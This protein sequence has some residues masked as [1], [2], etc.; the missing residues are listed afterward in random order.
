MSETVVV[1]ARG[2]ACPM[3]VIKAK[4]ALE[5]ARPGDRI[6][7]M[8]DGE[9]ARDNVSRMAKTAGCA[10]EVRPEAMGFRLRIT[11]GAPLAAGTA[12]AASCPGETP[13]VVVYVN[14]DKVG[15]GSDELGGILMKAFL[16]TLKDVS[17]R[18]EKAVFVN[19]GVFLTTEGSPA[20]PALRALEAAGVGIH[21]CGT[22]LDYYKL[23]DKVQVG[24]VSNM[25][26]IVTF[27]ANADRVLKP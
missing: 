2:L 5:A 19:S 8:V 11:V 27:L 16:Q 13:R 10:V 26:E 6:E 20:L 3:P 15:H 9:A 22:C 18:P 24:V 12:P 25:F 17:P 4:K 23:L 7:V 1:D 21:S 14:S